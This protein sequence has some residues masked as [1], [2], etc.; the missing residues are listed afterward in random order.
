[1]SVSL[2]EG[3]R[4]LR[5]Q[6]KA[7]ED[8]HLVETERLLGE[9]HGELRQQARSLKTAFETSLDDELSTFASDIRKQLE[10]RRDFLAK[11]D[12]DWREVMTENLDQTSR[13]LR[14]LLEAHRALM[15]DPS[16]RRW[17]SS[18]SNSAKKVES[19]ARELDRVP[20]K[21]EQSVLNTAREARREMAVETDRLKRAIEPWKMVLASSLVAGV[22][23][24][25]IGGLVG[26]RLGHNS[27][28]DVSV[29]A[30]K[31]LLAYDQYVMDELYPNLNEKRK[32]QILEVRH[33]V[34]FP[35]EK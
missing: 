8:E 11:L 19:A 23:A 25:M 28:K 32:A 27:G 9:L 1:M 18:F 29:A 33:S 21:L 14:E 4:R 15:A 12:Q 6:S 2:E 10:Q 3:L 35:D 26:W 22:L 16:A 34:G 7:M 30:M 24:M 13:E 20:A 17:S 31:N 5:R